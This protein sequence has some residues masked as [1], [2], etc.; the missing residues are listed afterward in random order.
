[1]LFSLHIN[2]I[3]ADIESEIRLF[4]DDCVCYREIKDK[5]DTLKLQRDIDRLGNWA[6]KWGM[7]FQPV[8]CNMMQLTNKH[9][10]KIQASYTLEGTVLENVDNIKYLGV[11][12]TNDL[13]WNTHISNICTKANRTLGFFRRTLFSC[14]QNVKEAAYKGMVRPILEYGSSVWDPHPDKLQEELEKVQNCAA[15]F[16]T[17]NYVYETGSMTGILGQLKWE[18][19]KKRRKDNR[20]ILLYKGLKGKARIP[21]DDLI[22][23]TRRGRNQHSLA[24]QIPSASKDVYQYSF[25]LQT[26]RDWTDLPESLILPLN[27]P[28]SPIGRIKILTYLIWG[29]LGAA[30]FDCIIRSC[31]LFYWFIRTC[32][33]PTVVPAA[34]TSL[35]FFCVLTMCYFSDNVSSKENIKILWLI[36]MFHYS[37][38]IA[39]KN[40]YWFFCFT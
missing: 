13:K 34:I 37:D 25:F 9:L 14:P 2:D 12:I 39:I 31:D 26:I 35:E 40:S 24:F 3:T 18:S 30:I 27:C 5:E 6:R 10:N 38:I 17:R 1:M 36:F 22:P 15:R 20:L 21:T 29:F 11:T 32:L 4:A 19:L 23:K 8:K 28:L 16:V 33:G 7:R